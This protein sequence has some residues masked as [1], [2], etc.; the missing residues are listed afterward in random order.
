MEEETISLQE[1]FQ[2]LKKRLAM[3]VIITFLVTAAAGVVSFFL[4]TPIYQSS[5]QL[6]V[7]QQATGA[8][9]ALEAVGFDT[10]AEYIETYNV[11]MKSP[12]ILDQVVEELGTD[13]K[14]SQLNQKLNIS[15]EGES[16]VITL[17]VEDPD[18]ARAVEIANTTASVFEREISDLLRIDNI[19]VLAPAELSE[20]PAPVKPQPLLNMAIAF[21]VGLMAAIGLSFLLEYLDNTYRN[22]EDIER[23]LGLS[24]LGSV[25]LIDETNYRSTAG[26]GSASS[27]T[28]KGREKV[29]S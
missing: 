26:K 2:T 28:R 13:E 20:N 19:V 12:Y 11:I 25:P 15:R 17:T 4:L 14:A 10:D 24:V 27:R 5:T 23:E 9:S 1:V 16:Q 29:G 8:Q 18:P 22:E 6:L 7:S 3:I 21:V